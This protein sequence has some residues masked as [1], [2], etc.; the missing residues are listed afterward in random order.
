MKVSRIPH[1]YFGKIKYANELLRHIKTNS[2]N[3]LKYSDCTQ[4]PVKPSHC[5]CR[6]GSHSV[7]C[8]PAEVTFLPLPQP[9]KAG[10]QFSTPGGCN[11]ELAGYIPRLHTSRQMVTDPKTG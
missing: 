5:Y 1:K 7:T 9:N 3:K 4:Q 8:H 2:G 11:A 10:T 6:T